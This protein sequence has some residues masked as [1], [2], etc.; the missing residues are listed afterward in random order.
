MW[1]DNN[2][3][4]WPEI[5]NNEEVDGSDQVIE[6]EQQQAITTDDQVDGAVCSGSTQPAPSETEIG[7]AEI[8]RRF[9][10][11]SLQQRRSGKWSLFQPDTYG[12][13]RPG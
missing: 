1:H 2:S 12:T 11:S 10:G 7:K 9:E 8:A 3:R 13:F 5:D 6:V 4:D